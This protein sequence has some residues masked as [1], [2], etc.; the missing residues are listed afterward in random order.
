MFPKTAPTAPTRSNIPP[1]APVSNWSVALYRKA[2]PILPLNPLDVSQTSTPQQTNGSFYVQLQQ[3]AAAS[4]PS[5][6]DVLYFRY[7]AQQQKNSA[8]SYALPFTISQLNNM[9]LSPDIAP[10]TSTSSSRYTSTEQQSGFNDSS[11]N[12]PTL[13]L[14]AKAFLGVLILN[15]SP[16]SITAN[17][18]GIIRPFMIFVT[19]EVFIGQLFDAYIFRISQV[20][21]ISMRDNPEDEVFVS[22][23][24]K[25][26]Q[27]RSFYYAS[28]FNPE[29]N[30]NKRY[31]TKPYDITLCAQRMVH[32]HDSDIRFFWNRGLCL[33]LLKFNID[34]RYWIPK[35]MCGGFETYR[36][37]NED[38]E[39]WLISRLSCERAGTRF[40]V[41][42]VNDDGAVA[43]FVETEQI[44]FVPRQNHYSSFVIIRGSI[45]L[46]WHQPGFQVGTHRITVL[47]SEALSFKAFFEHFKYLY[48]HYGRVLIINLVDK[49]EDEKRIGEEY[50]NL[51]ELLVKTYQSK[52]KKEK[53]LLG[54]LTEKDFIWFGYHEQ[55]REAKG[56]TPEQF[57][58]Q[59]LIQNKQYSIGPELER[60][61]IFTFM[62][63]TISSLQQ[64]VFRINCIDCLDR[65]NNV[66]LT[67]GMIALTMQIASLKKKVNVNNLV[68][69]LKDMWINNGD[70]ISRI[71]TGTGA[72]G[73]RNKAKDI[74]R[75]LG[76]VIQNNLRDDE[77][78]QSI[79][80]LIYSYAKDSYLHERSVA[81]LQTP[82]VISDGII[83]TEL[84][85]MRPEFVRK[86]KFRV[87]IG[88]W[89]INGDKNP[90]LENE[91]PSILD[92]W[93][94]D[95]PENLSAKTRKTNSI[96][97]NGF[98]SDDYV[99][100]MPDILAIGFQEI[101]DL[102]ATNMVW[103]S[104]VNA[105]RWV[106]N[107]QA[108]FK[109]S[110]PNDEYILLGNDQLVGV[111]LAIF[112]RRDHA[113]FVKNVIVDSVKTG[114]GG[115]IGNKGCVAIRLVLYNTSICFLCAHFTAGQNEFNERNKDYKSIMEKLSFQPPS[116]ALWHD[117]IFF[118]GDF[119]Y[120]LTIPRAQV[121]QFIKNEAYSQ[122]LEYD[123]L[124]KEHSEGRVFREFIEGPIKFPPTYKYD[125]G[126]DEYDTSE[127]ARTPSYTDRILWRS[128]FPNVQTKQ[129]YYGRAE[130]KTSDHRPISAM[131]DIDVE[132]CDETKMH[133]KYINIY[134]RF[135]P[136]NAQIAFDMKSDVNINKT[137]LI[138]EFD[139]YVK[140]KYGYNINIIDRFF[141]T[142]GTYVSLNMSFENGEHA[143][144]VME[145]TQD[146]LPNGLG[147]N[148]RL[149]KLNEEIALN[150]KLNTLFSNV[151]ET[152]YPKSIAYDLGCYQQPA[153]ES[154]STLQDLTAVNMVVDE[155][156]MITT[157]KSNNEN[158]TDKYDNDTLESIDECKRIYEQRRRH[159]G[160]IFTQDTDSDYENE[161]NDRTNVRSKTLVN[162][163]ND[164]PTSTDTDSPYGSDS[165][166]SSS[167]DEYHAERKI[168]KKK[169]HRSHKGPLKLYLQEKIGFWPKDRYEKRKMHHLKKQG[170][171]INYGEVHTK[172]I[173]ESLKEETRERQKEKP[174]SIN[175]INAIGTL[176]RNMSFVSLDPEFSIAPAEFDAASLASSLM[177][178]ADNE[179]TDSKLSSPFKMM[180]TKI[181]NSLRRK[182]KTSTR[183]DVDDEQMANNSD[184]ASRISD[185][186]DDESILTDGNRQDYNVGELISFASFDIPA[187]T[188]V[189]D[190]KANTLVNDNIFDPFNLYSTSTSTESGADKNNDFFSL[191]HYPPVTNSSFHSDPFDLNR[192]LSQETNSSVNI[193][194]S[195]LT[196]NNN[197]I[198]LSQ[199]QHI[200]TRVLTPTPA[201][202]TTQ[203]L[204]TLKNL[205]VNPSKQKNEVASDLLDW[206][207][208]GP[209]LESLQFDP[210]A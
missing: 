185:I 88:T 156:D 126:S 87:S 197:F 12:P 21:T 99:K 18:V 98:V 133:K 100:L 122:L 132:I 52:Q 91:Y 164:A 16:N 40:N 92:A 42:G 63:E 143:Q 103:Q 116:R 204:L 128:I 166:S 198:A 194:S 191:G 61:N 171:E 202:N 149:I 58:D 110:Y 83:L 67:I 172:E 119:N 90:A 44:V 26:F 173:K 145:P 209:S 48:R 35:I 28:F 76:R 56:L 24:K 115:K 118:L 81:A 189:D 150:Q 8:D 160:D 124:K 15:S 80:T 7:Q 131:F 95:G 50:Q 43:N 82:Y 135:S 45:P 123:Q 146:Q 75:S 190:Q 54:Y 112:I 159:F 167:Y 162:S 3:Q 51:F 62:D 27:G 129:L 208:E 55:A 207:D 31:F 201:A 20:A 108:H 161:N 59:M 130:V 210:Y 168:Q 104:S 140:R 1:A 68:D 96:S 89:N 134:E 157:L 69:R 72:L 200:S 144:K 153:R 22:G 71:Y 66:Q 113:P 192:H 84:F 155:N 120:R 152:M 139:K 165:E 79:Q 147:F 34:I 36:N 105:T 195:N 180:K 49:R 65:T 97:T 158:E 154:L 29:L 193:F 199:P 86:E 114:M 148:K 203:P 170:I 32:G 37:P 142:N 196:N 101:C 19:E 175:F 60:Q 11:D 64:G 136:S 163:D 85:R 77:K 102:T 183:L 188:Y 14:R 38:I 109:K 141:T 41:R 138:E 106:D 117:H 9:S 176:A 6:S 10:I 187:D 5:C 107:V 151:D 2:E 169:V 17:T 121:E 30:N 39:L 33:P 53:P 4:S 182:R 125:V 70:H 13:L 111:C 179:Q 23:I 181:R 178:A 57:V 186:P 93:I 127:K 74:Q 47:R 177:N 184:T 94:L 174:P 25:L 73:Q 78:Q 205:T 46:F 206:N 137:Q